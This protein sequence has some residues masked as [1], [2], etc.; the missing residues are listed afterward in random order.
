MG[1]E[2]YRDAGEAEW[3]KPFPVGTELQQGSQAIHL[4][5]YGGRAADVRGRGRAESKQRD[6]V[7]PVFVFDLLRP[8]GSP[9]WGCNLLE[10]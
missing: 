7:E 4:S 10:D 1:G 2:S 6:L 5:G 3:E 8:H 9:G